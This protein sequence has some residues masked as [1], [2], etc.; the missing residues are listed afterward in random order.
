MSPSATGLPRI[1]RVRR[2]NPAD[3][4]RV[5][6]VQVNN[7]FSGQNYFPYSIGILQAYAER[8]LK[9]LERYEFMLPV[10][11]RTTVQ[12]AFE[13]IK[14]ADVVFF[15]TYVW[16]IRFSLELARRLKSAR[17]EVLTVFGGPQVPNHVEDFLRKNTVVDVACH[18][19]GE[20]VFVAL[21]DRGLYGDWES[22]PSISYLTEDGSLVQR[23]LVERLK[24]M[25]AVPSPYLSGTFD[26][27]MKAYPKE[28]WIVMWETNRGCPFSCTFC[29]WGSAVASKVFQFE[30]PRILKE[31]DWFADHRIEFIFCADANFGMLPR[32]YDIVHYAAKTKT[33]R[34]Y[35]RALSVQNT[36]NATERAYSVQKLLS[37]AGL[38]KGVTIALQSVDPDTLK[39]I[40]RANIS[41]ESFQELQRRFTRDGV[42]TYS[43]IILGLPGETYESFATGTSDVI[44]NG[45]HNRIQFNNLSILPNAEMGDPDYQKKYGMEIVET[46]VV[47]I[48]GSIADDASADGIYETQHLVVG[49]SSMPRPDWVRTRAFSWMT[50]LLHFD[51]ILQ[52][53]L[54]LVHEQTRVRYRDLIEL[55]MEGSL[56]GYPALSEIR[57]F[58]LAKAKDIQDGGAEYVHSEK[59]LN[60]WWPADEH[61]FI[62]MSVEGKLEQFYEEA[63]RRLQSYL[64]ERGLKLPPGLLHDAVVLNRSLVKQPFQTADVDVTLSFNVWEFYHSVP[65]GLGVALERKPR[66]YRVN[67]T[68]ASWSSWNDWCREVVWYGNKKGAYLYSNSLV[69]PELAGH[70]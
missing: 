49:T 69:E 37:D 8:H 25:A 56:E 19:E 54:I 50:A 31:I 45:Q 65:R 4:I 38:N 32:D 17:P 33:S 16:N 3:P 5:G 29:D 23:P 14:D 68:K 39:S 57:D 7:S 30:L 1:S 53:P 46:R 44:E 40:K 42:E 70:F 36:K 10:Y 61:A 24:D 13:K 26:A 9:N 51:K 34:G 55:F 41:T 67:R 21:L 66:T 27:L 47:N 62:K 35:P 2:E 48:H 28:N 18:G 22:V 52:I 12:D 63:E 15:S 43:D 6:L 60:I 11:S 64:D 59:W 58:F 20:Q